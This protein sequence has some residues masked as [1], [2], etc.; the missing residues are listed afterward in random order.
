MNVEEASVPDTSAPRR[1]VLLVAG[2]LAAVV[3]AAYSNTFQVPFIADDPGSIAEN[4]TIRRLWPPWQAFCPP[5]GGVTASGRPLL[6]FSLAVNH[7]ISG[8]E[9]WSY[10]ALNLLIHFFAAFT[11][12]GVVRRTLGQPLL[13]PRFGADVLPLAAAVA[14]L[15]LLHPLQTEAVTYVTQRAES[16]AGLFYLLTLYC[17]IRGIAAPAEKA[18]GPSSPQRAPRVRR[19]S[20]FHETHERHRQDAWFLLSILACLLGMATKEIAVTAPLAV[21]LYDRIFAAGSLGEAW[22]RRRWLYIGLAGSWILLALLVAGTGWNRAGTVGFSVGVAPWAYWLTQA[23]AVVHYL[24]LAF[25][26]HPLVFDYG[27][28]WAGLG[29]AAPYALVVAPLLLATVWGLRRHPAAGFLGACFFGILAPTSLAPG[30]IQMIVEHRMYLPLAAA[31]AGAVAGMHALLGRRSL[32]L[33]GALAIGL[34]WLTFSRNATYASELSLWRDTVAKE[35]RNARARYNLGIAYSE[36]GEHAPAV[37]QGEAALRLDDGRT[38]AGKVPAIHN[39]L[40]YDLEALGRL[41]EAVAHYEQALRLKPDYVR[42]HRNLARVLQKMDRG[43]EAIGHYEAALRLNGG[44]SETEIELGDALLGERRLREAIGCYRDALLRAP[45]SAPG[46][47]S[48]GCALLLTG[49]AGR[50]IASYC[51]ALRLAPD[52]APAHRGLAEA[53]RRSGCEAE[54]AAHLA[55]AARLEAAGAVR[56]GNARN[57]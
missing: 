16:L 6:N 40:A 13:L 24:K 48:L 19:G 39:K 17:F 28:F 38:F 9:V 36:R 20:F 50:S 43:P 27:T 10:H 21:L 52:Y 57:R 14:G 42:A 54:A 55:E 7:A 2:V 30:T 26:P 31:I 49:D 4:A 41:P 25:W 47:S 35:P 18:E 56:P 32:V 22:R 12:F 46:F 1:V 15:W 37:E 34:G 45:T 8:E 5:S 51:E 23:E 11:L 53:L 3:L 33:W 29:E 44:D